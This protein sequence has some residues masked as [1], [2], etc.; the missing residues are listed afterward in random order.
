VPQ[1]NF[2]LQ[3]ENLIFDMFDC[4]WCHVQSNCIEEIKRHVKT[5]HSFY[6]NSCVKKLDTWLQLLIHS[7]DCVDSMLNLESCVAQLHTSVHVAKPSICW[8]LQ[9]I[10]FKLDVT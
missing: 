5:V 9:K 8:S 2:W 3:S 6:C 4:V 10:V 7:E 1:E